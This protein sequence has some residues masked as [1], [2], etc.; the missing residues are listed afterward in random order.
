M[1]FLLSII[2]WITFVGGLWF[3]T[4]QRDA[5]LPD[6]PLAVK[7]AEIVQGDYILEL[8]PTFSIED[9]PFALQSESEVSDSFEV[10]LNG[11]ELELPD[12]EL[13]R[14]KVLKIRNLPE[15]LS[16]FNEFFVSASPP[17]S[18][19]DL[20]HGIRIRLMDGEQI[21]ADHTVWTSG[22]ARVSGTMNFKLTTEKDLDHDH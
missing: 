18:E 22:G 11:Q 10:R 12:E 17:I 4:W 19:I 6:S 14:G 15:V 16:G 20:D 13:R 8:T 3:Y 2:I 21:I 7:P 1:R 9:D 5:K